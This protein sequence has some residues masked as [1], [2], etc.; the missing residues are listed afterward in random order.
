M[1]CHPTF[2]RTLVEAKGGKLKAVSADK[3]NPDNRASFVC[4]GSTNKIFVNSGRLLPP[5]S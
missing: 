4:G 5:N 2:C 3:D 1:N